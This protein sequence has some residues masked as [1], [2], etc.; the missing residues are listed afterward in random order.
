MGMFQDTRDPEPLQEEHIDP[1]KREETNDEEQK[2]KENPKE[3]VFQKVE[4]DLEAMFAGLD[5]NDNADDIPETKPTPG[6]VKR[7]S[8]IK[9]EPRKSKVESKVK[10]ENEKK[11]RNKKLRAARNDSESDTFDYNPED[12]QEPAFKPEVPARSKSKRKSA[13]NA[14]LRFRESNSDDDD[15]LMKRYL[16]SSIKTKTE[17]STI[18]EN[19]TESIKA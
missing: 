18:E 2:N 8:R 9:S 10:S 14:E 17:K 19:L 13:Q 6:A 4:D 7:K 1:K 3:Q 12:D 15:F 11:K 16:L 5:D